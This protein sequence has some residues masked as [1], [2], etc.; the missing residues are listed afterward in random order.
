MRE[1]AQLADTPFFRA[2]HGRPAPGGTY[3]DVNCNRLKKGV[4]ASE[5]LK[6]GKITPAK[7]SAKQPSIFLTGHREITTINLRF[8]VVKII[9]KSS[10][11]YTNQQQTNIFKLHAVQ[12]SVTPSPSAG[13]NRHKIFKS[14]LK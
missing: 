12:T 3:K 7:K 8:I 10:Y 11:F 1:K 9:S 13:A 5:R 14:N 2:G 6:P 4:P